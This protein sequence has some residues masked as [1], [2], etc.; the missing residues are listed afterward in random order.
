MK[1]S[2]VAV[3]LLAVLPV[4]PAKAGGDHRP[5]PGVPDAPLIFASPIHAGCYIA[6]PG[7][8]KIHAEPFTIEIAS[9]QKLVNFRL[10]ALLGPFLTQT[11]IYDFRPD[12]SNPVPSSGT[13]FTPS[14]VAMDFAA[15]CGSSYMLNLQGQDTG[16]TGPFSLGL[17]GLFTCPSTVP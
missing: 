8:C 3:L 5:T 6:A 12:Q 1:L 2:R 15:T 11:V 9:G 4:A 16:D 7:Q 10:V 17:T 14:L 13:T